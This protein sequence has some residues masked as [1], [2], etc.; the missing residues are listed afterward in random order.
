MDK[1]PNRVEAS[2]QVN[3]PASTGPTRREFL[4]ESAATLSGWL[5]A[6]S[7][8]GSAKTAAAL[9]LS[10]KPA[11]VGGDDRLARSYELRVKA[12]QHA[13]ELGAT[14]H[15]TNGDED[16]LVV[17]QASSD[18]SRRPF[19]PLAALLLLD[20]VPLRLRRSAWPATRIPR[21]I[22]SSLEA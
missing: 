5:L 14:A 17:C 9:E 11:P 10:R 3:R 16:L 19:T 2:S 6:P 13:R 1:N 12:A 22:H 15:P 8:L 18:A 21:R 4:G 20:V 7:L